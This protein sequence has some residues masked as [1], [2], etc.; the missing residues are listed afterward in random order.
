MDQVTFPAMRSRIGILVILVVAAFAL[1]LGRREN[2][3]KNV[4][5]PSEQTRAATSTVLLEDD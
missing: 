5:G 3:A 1:L 4:E 2:S